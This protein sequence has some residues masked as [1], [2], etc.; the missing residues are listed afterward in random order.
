MKAK[1]V[2]KKLALHKLT[3][4]D[5]NQDEMKAIVGGDE[6]TCG[7]CMSDCFCSTILTEP[8]VSVFATCG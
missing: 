4:A 6:H 2:E 3:I 1:R 5:L 7:S 8:K